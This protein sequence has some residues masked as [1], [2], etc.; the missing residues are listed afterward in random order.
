MKYYIISFVSSALIFNWQCISNSC[1]NQITRNVICSTAATALFTCD[2]QNEIK[3]SPCETV[4]AVIWNE[5]CYLPC[6]RNADEKWESIMLHVVSGVK[7]GV[8][9]AVT[10]KSGCWTLCCII[11]SSNSTLQHHRSGGT[12]YLRKCNTGRIWQIFHQLITMPIYIT[13]LIH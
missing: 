9:G 5:D 13:A 4:C 11:L 1:P 7:D 3:Y 2:E 6:A 10:E 12:W 8:S